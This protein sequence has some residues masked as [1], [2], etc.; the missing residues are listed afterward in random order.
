MEY[1]LPPVRTISA[2][3]WSFLIFSAFIAR[4]NE[5]KNKYQ[6]VHL[7]VKG[8]IFVLIG[9]PVLIIEPIKRK[10][11]IGCFQ[12]MNMFPSENHMFRDK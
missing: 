4:I 10:L 5:Y 3:C 1:T 6:K 11:S 2:F 12:S 8:I 7:N 9:D